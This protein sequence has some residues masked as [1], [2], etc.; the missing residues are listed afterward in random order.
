M[1]KG[2]KPR[3]GYNDNYRNSAAFQL[4]N[5]RVIFDGE[6]YV[7]YDEYDNVIAEGNVE[8]FVINKVN[9]YYKNR[10]LTGSSSDMKGAIL[11]G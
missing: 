3:S 10:V 11:N 2:S 8:Q 9:S 4:Q 6:N 1:S 5:G 7:G